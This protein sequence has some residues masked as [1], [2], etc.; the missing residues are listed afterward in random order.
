MEKQTE[1]KDVNFLGQLGRLHSHEIFVTLSAESVFPGQRPNAR[2]TP[3]ERQNVFSLTHKQNFLTGVRNFFFP[4]QIQKYE[5]LIFPVK[6]A[7][8]L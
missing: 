4:S 2:W 8:L 5:R 7:Q 1:N 3:L 6:T